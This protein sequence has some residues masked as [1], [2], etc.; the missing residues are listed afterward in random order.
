MRLAVEPRGEEMVELVRLA[1][2]EEQARDRI[3]AVEL[4]ARQAGAELAEAREALVQLEVG[5]PT[6]QER[7]KAEK[8][9]A[10][11]EQNAA[12]PWPQR[13]EGAQRAA[14]H[15]VARYA[16]DHLAELVAEVE[17]DG[18]D[19]A[20][21]LNA[22]GQILAARSDVASRRSENPPLSGFRPQP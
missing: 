20:D 13:I 15:T 2:V 12:K 14:R 16:A 19:A 18:R 8:R 17:D 5:T 22:A 10:D 11:A 9:L 4:D 21:Q 6:T 3:T 7:T 1:G